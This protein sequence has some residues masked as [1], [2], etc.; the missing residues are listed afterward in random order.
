MQAEEMLLG[1]YLL[2]TPKPAPGTRAGSAESHGAIRAH[3]AAGGKGRTPPPCQ[4]P[5]RR[6]LMPRVALLRV[7]QSL[8][9]R[10]LMGRASHAAPGAR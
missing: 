5:A 2:A 8:R 9:G 4:G 10:R 1:G 3:R 6:W 7:S